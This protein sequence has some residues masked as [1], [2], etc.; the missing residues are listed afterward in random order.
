MNSLSLIGAACILSVTL[1]LGVG[2]AFASD[3][4]DFHAAA[5]EAFAPYRTALAYLRTGNVDTAAFELEA[6]IAAWAALE[7][8]FA[9]APPD[10]FADDA[11]Y[12]PV[13]RRIGKDAQAALAAID[14][15]DPEGAAGLLKPLQAQLGGLRRRNGLY[16]LSDCVAEFYGA[17]DALWVYRH[18]MP[19][20]SGAEAR[21]EVLG[22]AAVVAYATG[23]C[24]AMAGPALREDPEFRR[25]FD[26]FHDGMPPLREAVLDQDG[27]RVIS[28][29]RELRSA[30]MLIYLRFG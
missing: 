30:Q 16:L 19:D 28:V 6:M 4:S 11:G 10:A 17:M 25:L 15:G 9:A 22:R 1:A 20:L 2:K 23:R 12:A 26:T 8:R 14:A 18:E 27:Q 7:G 21:A 3:L 5:E 29:L 24:E 13:L